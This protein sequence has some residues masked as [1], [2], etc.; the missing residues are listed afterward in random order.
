MVNLCG[1]ME[2][3][4]KEHPLKIGQTPNNCQHRLLRIVHFANI[5]DKHPFAYFD[6]RLSK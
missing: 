3:D 5:F 6:K 2:A 4:F 1:A